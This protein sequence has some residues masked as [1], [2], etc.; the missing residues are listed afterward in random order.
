MEMFKITNEIKRGLARDVKR[1][2]NEEFKNSVYCELVVMYDVGTQEF[3]L[4]PTWKCE[5]EESIGNCLYKR[6]SFHDTDKLTLKELEY[7]IFS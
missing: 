1:W 7:T 3:Y 4:I 6:L 5:C 2:V